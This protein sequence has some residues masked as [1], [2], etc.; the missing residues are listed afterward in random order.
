MLVSPRPFDTLPQPHV[1]RV[2]LHALAVILK[3]LGASWFFRGAGERKIA[4]F[5]Q[6]RR[7]EKH[8]VY[9]I[10]IKRVAE[11]TFVD[12]QG[13]QT[14]PFCF[15]GTGQ[16][17]R[18]RSDANQVEYGHENSLPCDRRICNQRE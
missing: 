3:S 8:H 11:A 13:V 10:M 5:E 17:S 15:N 2:V 4:D 12:H 6:L 7:G 9:G 1:Q 16:T 14:R 18:A